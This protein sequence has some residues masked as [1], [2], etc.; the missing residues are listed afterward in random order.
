MADPIASLGFFSGL[1]NVDDPMRL[2]PIPVKI[3]MGGYK[4]AYPL[5]QAVNVD[6]DNT[7]GLSSRNGSTK[8]LSCTDSHSGWA[9][10]RLG[11]FVDGTALYVLDGTAGEEPDGDYSITQLLTGLAPGARMSYFPV[12]DRVYMTNGSYIG[13][14]SNLSMHSL[15]DPGKEYKVPLPAGKFIA[16]RKG[17]LYVA[18]GKVLYKSDALCDHYDVRTGFSVL[19]NDITM[20]RPVDDGIYVSDGKTWFLVEKRAFA[21]DPAELKKEPVLDNDAIPYTDVNINGKDLAEGTEGTFAMWCSQDG[22]CIGDNKGTVVIKNKD[23][24][25]FTPRAIGAAAVRSVNGIT[26]YLTVLE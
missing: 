23:T 26:H 17:V 9:N 18:K 22:I 2:P 15:A 3:G 12:N 1:N 4:A 7:Y 24:Y 13:Y 6:I 25:Y 16:Y 20:L 8:K 10:G 14:Y 5:V 11:F 19:E 21:D